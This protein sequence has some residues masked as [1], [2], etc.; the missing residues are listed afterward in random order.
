MSNLTYRLSIPTTAPSST[1]SKGT[2]LSSIEIDKNFFSLNDSKVET[3]DCVSTNTANKIVKRDA[4]GDFAANIITVVDLNSTSD[5]RLKENIRPII[6]GLD[7]VKNLH[8]VRFNFNFGDTEKERIGL[9]AQDVELVLPEVV[10]DND[11]TL[12][13]TYQNIVSVLIEAIKELSEKVTEL[14]KLNSTF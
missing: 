14:E 4:S 8:G 7:L 10:N 5:R 9:I 2:G 1:T 13:I 6:G 12:H 11:G 3:T